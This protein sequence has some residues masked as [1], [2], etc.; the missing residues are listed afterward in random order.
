MT[1]KLIAL[2]TLAATMASPLTAL[3]QTPAV[4][5]EDIRE[6]RPATAEEKAEF[7]KSVLF[8]KR[9]NE[10]GDFR[11][12]WEQFEAADRIF[13]DQ[14]GVLFN[15]SVLLIRLGRFSDAQ[16]RVNRYQNLYPEGTEIARVR[17]LQ[18]ELD[19]QRELEKRQQAAKSYVELFNR[20]RF[21]LANGNFENAMRILDEASQ[22]KPNDPAVA[23]NQALVHE[24][25]GQF[26]KATEQFRRYLELASGA[27][28]KNEIDQRLFRLESEINDM[29][30]KFVCSF[31]GHK[32]PLGATW[33]HRCWHGPYLFDSPQWNARPC[34]VGAT[35]TRTTFYQ[36][37]RFGGNEEL[38]CMVKGGG[39]LKD[40]LRYTP[41]RQKAIQNARKA[42]GWR[43]DGDVIKEKAIGSRA[44]VQLDQGPDYLERLRALGS[45]DVLSYTA[46]K[47][48]NEWLLSTEDL[49]FDGVEFVKTYT[50]AGTKISQ[51]KVTY[52]NRAACDHLVTSLATYQY[53]GDRIG[54]VQLSAGYTGFRA[55][56][57][58]VVEW[59]G[60]LVFAYDDKGRLE[61]EEFTIDSHTKNYTEKPGSETR[62]LI[63]DIYPSF[64]P[65][66]P[67]DVVRTGDLCGTAGNRRL[68]NQIDLRPF[69]TI[70]PSFP[71]LLPFGT[72]K[73][74]IDY[75]YPDDYVVTSK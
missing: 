12:A 18:L 22:Q 38:A 16:S 26:A 29:Q 21:E 5:A 6:M 57:V 42:E 39:R 2:V 19:F 37:G 9:F 59:S 32:L 46:T 28:N 45:G 41:E 34:A 8:G 54:S 44:V 66:K 52:Q 7:E 65:K 68:G 55:E 20:G 47:Q 64:R 30:S 58:P 33:C 72:Q 69:Y 17:M 3:A 10:I 35:A 67:M 61:K 73:M 53:T 14:P 4:E 15:L 13:P 63:K 31:C 60:R 1:R 50:Y 43:Y 11:A 24:R 36:D 51:E 75:T 49:V 62:K 40:V 56:G 23:Y 27:A 25:L 74:T 70:S 71:A 48:G